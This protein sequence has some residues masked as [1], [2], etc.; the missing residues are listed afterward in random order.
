M[1]T[2]NELREKLEKI[3]WRH[4]NP[5][6]ALNVEE[7][8]DEIMPLLSSQDTCPD[9]DPKDEH[10]DP[11]DSSTTRISRPCSGCGKHQTIAGALL[12]SGQWKK[13]YDNASKNMIFDVDETEMIDAMSD[14]H[15]Q[16]FMKFSSQDTIG[17][18]KERLGDDF[19]NLIFRKD[20]MWEVCTSELNHWA[21][22]AEGDTPLQALQNLEKEINKKK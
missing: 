8:L 1:K 6:S 11:K 20:G 19:G 10:I 18:V 9:C 15:F 13:W 2:N 12:K 17:G 4:Y 7:L 5:G 16:E 21:K 3:I 22:I 14:E